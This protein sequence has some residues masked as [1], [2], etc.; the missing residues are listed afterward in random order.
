[1]KTT[2]IHQAMKEAKSLRAKSNECKLKLFALLQNLKETGVWRKDSFWKGASEEL[3]EYQ[4]KKFS[5]LMKDLFDKSNQWY[6]KTEE[7]LSK[8]PNGRDM[9]IKY[10][11]RNMVAYLGFDEKERKNVL[12]IAKDHPTSCFHYLLNSRGLKGAKTGVT[13]TEL[14]VIDTEWK[15]RHHQVKK[16]KTSLQR[17]YDKL[18]KDYD[19]LKGRYNEVVKENKQLWRQQK[20]ISKLLGTDSS[21]INE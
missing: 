20:N 15:D 8:V 14:K 17:K 11:H 7:I 9:Y 4:H 19:I 10:G 6:T 5:A 12:I 16:E 13:K 21:A 3:A 1:M 18:K 2:T